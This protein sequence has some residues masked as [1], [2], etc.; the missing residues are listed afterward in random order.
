MM[1]KLGMLKDKGSGMLSWCGKHKLLSIIV[2]ILAIGLFYNNV[3]AKTNPLGSATNASSGQTD[4]EKDLLTSSVQAFLKEYGC[5]SYL[6]ALDSKGM[7]TYAH[8]DLCKAVMGDR[9]AAYIYPGETFDEQTQRVVALDRMKNLALVRTFDLN[10]MSL[11]SEATDTYQIRAEVE[12]F[13]FRNDTGI[14]S[15]DATYVVE[16]RKNEAPGTNSPYEVIR[17]FKE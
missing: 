3:I 16:V 6:D 5:Y 17:I 13:T 7:E 8:E 9:V 2:A 10:T 14:K 15:A 4:Q 1:E 11:V 12:E